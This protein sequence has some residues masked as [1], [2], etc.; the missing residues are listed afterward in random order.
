MGIEGG[1]CRSRAPRDSRDWGGER[2]RLRS[3]VLRL[4]G[5]LGWQP[6]EVIDFAEAVAGCPWHECGCAEF[7]AVLEEYRALL[8][9]FRAKMARRGASG[10]EH[11]PS[12]G[13]GDS[14]APSD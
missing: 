9:L 1:G 11:V 12:V 10:R 4:G 3:G 5:L 7:T 13:A 14:S 2:A 8:L 6:R